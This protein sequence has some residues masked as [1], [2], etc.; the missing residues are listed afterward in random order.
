MI[1]SNGPQYNVP[2]QLTIQKITSKNQ[3]FVKQTT[4]YN[5]FDFKSQKPDIFDFGLEACFEDVESKH[6]MVVFKNVGHDLIPDKH[7]F[8][9]Q[10]LKTIANLTY[11]LPTRIDQ[12]QVI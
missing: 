10:V 3:V 7:E 6:L 1:N 11:V 12:V 2:V 8:K 5:Y 9:Y 4:I